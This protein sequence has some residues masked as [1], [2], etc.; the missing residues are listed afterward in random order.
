MK[1]QSQTR[2]KTFK[3]FPGIRKDLKSGR[4]LAEASV[5]KKRMSKTF[6]SIDEAI[7]WRN[8]F[9]HFEFEEVLEEVNSTFKFKDLWER[10]KAEHL[11]LLQKSSQENRLAME[12]FFNGL[13]DY[14][15]NEITPGIISRHLLAQREVALKI[16]SHRRKNFDHELKL[17]KAIFNWHHDEIDHTFS[18]PV[19]RKH[20]TLGFVRVVEAKEKKLSIIELKLFL[21]AL[22]ERPFWYDFALTQL[23]IAG[24]VQEVAGLQKKNI[25]FKFR[26][27]LVKEVVVWSKKTKK[28]DELKGMP[29]NG[30]IR[31]IHLGDEL[32]R[33]LKKRIDQDAFNTGFV[34]HD[35]G[36]PLGYRQIQYNYDWAL[37]KAGLGDRFSGTHILRHSMATLT[38]QVTG[39]LNSTQAVTGHKDFKLVQHYAALDNGENKKAIMAVESHLIKN[40]FFNS[41]QITSN[42]E[43]G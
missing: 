11:P 37:K 15:V 26:N 28:F 43:Q 1:K 32:L 21:D 14:D 17:L 38:R 4:F 25:D 27:L 6:S 5:D 42:Y 24:R 20:K 36:Q 22:I 31:K 16:G 12:K 7:R 19:T 18:N 34:F 33:I 9:S 2:Y 13:W 41:E 30:E 10:Y 23:L 3:R 8:S 35:K 29:K 40:S 39:S